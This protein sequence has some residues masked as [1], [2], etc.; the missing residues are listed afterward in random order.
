MS[1]KTDVYYEYDEGHLTEEE[2]IDQLNAEYWTQ[3]TRQQRKT[4]QIEWLGEL[5]A[6]FGRIAQAILPESVTLAEEAVSSAVEE[7]MVVITAGR[8]SFVTRV[9]FAAFCRLIVRRRSYDGYTKYEGDI[10]RDPAKSRVSNAFR[11][12]RRRTAPHDTGDGEDFHPYE[13]WET[14]ETQ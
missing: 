7:I 4:Q 1:K 13:R 8:N 9:K 3:M 12:D 2:A 14:V 5:Y 11:P 10:R 6:G